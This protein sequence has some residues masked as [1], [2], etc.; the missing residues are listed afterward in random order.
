[1]CS[2]ALSTIQKILFNLSFLPS[3][4]TRAIE[5]VKL[6]HRDAALIGDKELSLAHWTLS[7]L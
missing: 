4:L 3:T 5:E 2:E 6:M 1:M 7:F